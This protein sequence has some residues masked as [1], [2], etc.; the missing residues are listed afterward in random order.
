M[1]A[2]FYDDYE[3]FEP[4][5]SWTTP[6]RVIRAEDIRAFAEATGDLNPIHLDLERAKRS[7]YRNVIAHGYLTISWAAGLVHRLGIDHI[8]SNAILQTTWRLLDVVEADEEIFVELSVIEHRPSRSKPGFGVVTRR[9]NVKA[10]PGRNVA[11]GTVT[12]LVFRRDEAFAR[13]LIDREGQPQ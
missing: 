1:T 7:G 9:F 3:R 10:A 6:S 12:I 2:L 4:D 8:S 5:H 11:R 13:G